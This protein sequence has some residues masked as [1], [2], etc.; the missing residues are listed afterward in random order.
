MV[1]GECYGLFDAYLHQTVFLRLVRGDIF[2]QAVSVVKAVQTQQWHP[3]DRA[4]GTPTYD[5]EQIAAAVRK[6]ARGVEELRLY[7]RLSGRPC[8]TLVYEDFS[9]GDFTGVSAAC[10]ALGVPRRGTDDDVMYRPID[11]M[12]DATNDAWRSR[13]IEEMDPATKDR[14]ERYADALRS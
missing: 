5:R 9:E 3:R 10:D 13:F 6:S 8:Q 11:R 14:V 12:G 1:A 7:A 4:L 2:A